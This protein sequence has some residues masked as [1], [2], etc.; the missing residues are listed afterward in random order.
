MPSPSAVHA[1]PEQLEVALRRLHPDAV[2]PRRAHADDAG[3][4][5]CTLD[6]VRLEPGERVLVGTGLA[7][8]LPPGY[9]GL[10]HPRSGLAARLGLGVLNAPGT[11][12]AGYR[13]E[14]K[15]CL[16]NHDRSATIELQRGDRVAQLLVQRVAQVSFV[17]VDE[18]ADTERGAGGHGST[19]MSTLGST[20]TEG[21]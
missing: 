20:T 9:V 2:V 18:L 8:A 17:E 16:V 14:I 4:D 1:A 7:L 21:Q 5:L 19:G 13:G 6:E 12:D 10:V 11:I 3:V 15:V